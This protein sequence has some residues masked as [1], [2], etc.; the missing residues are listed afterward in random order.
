MRRTDAIKMG[1]SDQHPEVGVQ[2]FLKGG[3]WQAW[4]LATSGFQ[5]LS[6]GLVHLSDVSVPP[7]VQGRL[8][9]CAKLVEPAVGS[10]STDADSCATGGFVPGI[11]FLHQN[12]HLLFCRLALLTFHTAFVFDSLFWF[13]S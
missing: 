9:L 10:G 1:D 7:I 6:D 8:S 5:P 11:S 12:H 13:L 4:L 2:L 3:A